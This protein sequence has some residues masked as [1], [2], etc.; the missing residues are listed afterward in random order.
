MARN[1]RL[2]CLLLV[3]ACSLAVSPAARADVVRLKNGGELRGE[4]QPPPRTAGRTAPAAEAASPATVTIRTL[5]GAIVTIAT[6][7]VEEVVRRRPLLEEYETLR[8]TTPDTVA[9]QWELAEWCRQKALAKERARHLA[10]IVELD[11][12]HVA[13]HRGLGHVRHEGRWTTSD[14]IMTARGYV[15]HKGRYV[16]PQ[17][18]EL[19]EAEQ[20]DDAAE[21]AW[22]KQI[23]LWENWLDSDRAERQAEGLNGLRSIHDANAVSALFRTFKNNNNEQKR[24]LYIEIMGHIP[25]DKPLNPLVQ[26]SLRDES[27]LVRDAAVIAIRRKDGASTA[28]PIYVRALKNEANVTVNRAANALAQ[29]GDETVVPLLIEA[30]VTRHRYKVLV[31]DQS[32]AISTDGSFASGGA[33]VPPEIAGMLA[34]GQLPNGVQIQGTGGQRMK[35]VVVQRDEQNPSVLSALNLLTREDFG[36]DEQAWRNWHK[37]HLAGNLKP[38]KKSSVV[39]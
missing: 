27:R 3:L 16:L 29:L 1:T 37:A 31:P 35:E 18:L 20:R 11:P 12:A 33:A 26:Q 8:Q 32:I 19:L 13:A 28:I 9:A 2:L 15:K 4:L 38:K 25:G 30:L 17:E 14:E 7:E 36:Y 22:Y 6:E 10:R 23:K 39:N 5:T 21:K 24:L 34:T